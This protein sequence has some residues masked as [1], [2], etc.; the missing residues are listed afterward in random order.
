MGNNNIQEADISD[1]IFYSSGR[2]F[3]TS[4]FLDFFA[5]IRELAFIYVSSGENT[6]HYRAIPDTKY[7]PSLVR[8]C[9]K[10]PLKTVSALRFG[11]RN[12]IKLTGLYRRAE[13]LNKI[14]RKEKAKFIYSH[15]LTGP[16]LVCYLSRIPYIV[17]IWG[18]DINKIRYFPE[19]EKL[20]IR[21]LQNASLIHVLSRRQCKILVDEGYARER[22]FIQHFGVDTEKFYP[23]KDKNT[24][25]QEMG[26]TGKTVI[27]APRGHSPVY[28]PEML[29]KV[30]KRVSQEITNLRVIITGEY[31]ETNQ[32]KKKASELDLDDIVIFVGR[33][34]REEYIAL[35]QMADLYLQT[36]EMDGVSVSIMESLAAGTPAVSSN[37]D[38]VSVNIRH[39]YNG[40]LIDGNDIDDY[41]NQIVELINNET[42]IGEM[43]LNGIKWAME[44]CRRDETM[45][46]ILAQLKKVSEMLKQ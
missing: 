31:K 7:S 1:F 16:G 25:K 4:N 38:D 15:Q 13:S 6:S 12:A 40:L 10:N 17:T 39:D 20:C 3:H 34:S 9:L 32:L 26:Y 33:V 36:P 35:N 29:L 46:N 27:F 19:L 45:R 23:K 42:R 43:S 11:P 5:G 22:I 24:L 8:Y 30:V 28:R 14:A 44:N 21:T 2:S 37:V 41:S 18:S